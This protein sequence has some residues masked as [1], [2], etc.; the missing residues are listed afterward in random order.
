MKLA[1]SESCG[2][3]VSASVSL[4]Y[5]VGL[6]DVPIGRTRERDTGYL[7][8]LFLIIACIFTM[9]SKVKA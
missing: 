3:I 8:M 5:T 4:Y 9:I 1:E 7:H 6:R 2:W